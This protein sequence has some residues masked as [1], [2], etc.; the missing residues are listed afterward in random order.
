MI[1]TKQK[2]ILIYEAKL[3]DLSIKS[4]NPHP[5]LFSIPDEVQ[6]ADYVY[7][8]KNLVLILK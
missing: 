4:E 7:A 2:K 1:K 8:H 6:D 5:E 3:S